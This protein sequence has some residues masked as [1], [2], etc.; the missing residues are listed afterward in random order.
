[1]PCPQWGQVVTYLIGIV[2]M[3]SYALAY[4]SSEVLSFGSETY[5]GSGVNW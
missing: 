2:L 4:S 5:I 1:M 3:N